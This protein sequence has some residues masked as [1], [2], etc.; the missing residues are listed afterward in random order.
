MLF[1][2]WSRIIISIL[3]IA[4]F[5]YYGEQSYYELGLMIL[6][7]LIIIEMQQR[8]FSNTEI[9]LAIHNK[10]PEDE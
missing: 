8:E 7:S 1:M 9:H 6:T 4:R 2:Q 5:Y 10:G 3:G